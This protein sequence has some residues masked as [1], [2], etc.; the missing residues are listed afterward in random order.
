M[1]SPASTRIL[2]AYLEAARN[3]EITVWFVGQN[4]QRE[5][6]SDFVAASWRKSHPQQKAEIHVGITLIY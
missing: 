2:W 6:A 5:K 3:V 4:K 1:S